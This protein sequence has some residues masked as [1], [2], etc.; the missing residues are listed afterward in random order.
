LKWW[1]RASGTWAAHWPN[2]IAW[3]RPPIPP[4]ILNLFVSHDRAFAQRLANRVL[5]LDR[6]RL[7]ILLKQIAPDSGNVRHGNRLQAAYF[8]Q[9]RDELEPDKSV[10]QNIAAGNDFIVFNNRKRHFFANS[11]PVLALDKRPAAW[12]NS[13]DLDR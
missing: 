6:G 7:K 11:F 4:V 5:E 9:L 8:D 2:T 13:L 3:L 12:E 10:V 1:Q